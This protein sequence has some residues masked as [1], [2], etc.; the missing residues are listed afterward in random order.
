MLHNDFYYCGEVNMWRE[1]DKYFP[2]LM[3]SDPL[4]IVTGIR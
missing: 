1:D 4:Y 2:S 3:V